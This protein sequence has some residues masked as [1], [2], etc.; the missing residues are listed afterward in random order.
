MV[1]R[2]VLLLQITLT[3]GHWKRTKWNP[4]ECEG[5]VAIKYLK[6]LYNNNNNNNLKRIGS[7]L[8]VDEYSV[9]IEFVPDRLFWC[10]I[11]AHPFAPLNHI[12]KSLIN[13]KLLGEH[14]YF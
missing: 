13:L 8:D 9:Q 7:Q 5:K 1:I 14:T 2:Q 10:V 6:I 11:K 12:L 4:H 3:H